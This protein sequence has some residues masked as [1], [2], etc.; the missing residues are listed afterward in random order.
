MIYPYDPNL[1]EILNSNPASVSPS[2]IPPLAGSVTADEVMN[3][4]AYEQSP[5]RSNLNCSGSEA[6][7]GTGHHTVIAHWRVVDLVQGFL[8]S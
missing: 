1:I 8:P 4:R 6:H 5:A 2:P 3:V 7:S